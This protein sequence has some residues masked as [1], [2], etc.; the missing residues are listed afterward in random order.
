LHHS[1][2][3]TGLAKTLIQSGGQEGTWYRRKP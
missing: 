2:A 1:S 3:A